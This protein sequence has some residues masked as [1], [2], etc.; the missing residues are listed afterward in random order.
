MTDVVFPGAGY[1]DARPRLIRPTLRLPATRSARATSLQRRLLVRRLVVAVLALG[2]ATIAM[3]D[4]RGRMDVGQVDHAQGIASSNLAGLRTDVVF[5]HAN[6]G[7]QRNQVRY[8]DAQMDQNRLAIGST[9]AQTQS[10]EAG[11]RFDTIDLSN[12]D[13]CLAGF[14][15]ALDQIGVG[16][17]LGGL[18]SLEAV[19]PVCKSATP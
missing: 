18:A 1:R 9:N 16:Q 19:G 14:T 8:L 2:V 11:I 5:T 7:D 15:Q 12:L 10:A 13:G 17:V 3:T 6:T 4:V